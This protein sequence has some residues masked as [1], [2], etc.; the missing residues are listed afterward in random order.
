MPA[1]PSCA[2]ALGCGK[3]VGKELVAHWHGHAL[4]DHALREQDKTS[5]AAPFPRLNRAFA[6]ALSTS[7]TQ[8]GSLA[9]RN[10]RAR[11]AGKAVGISLTPCP[12]GIS[13]I[14]THDVTALIRG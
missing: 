10:R 11:P 8:S 4:L 9:A 12:E 13:R 7:E 3:I 6:N 1:A 5:F 14:T 2:R